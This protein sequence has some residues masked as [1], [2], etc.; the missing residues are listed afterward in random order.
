M[1]KLLVICMAFI[2]LMPMFNV[3]A[4]ELTTNDRIGVV[5]DIDSTAQPL[6][7][8]PCPY[9]NG[10]CMMY[11]RGNGSIYVS[12]TGMVALSNKKCWQCNKCYTV[13]VTEGDVAIG[14]SFG[15]YAFAPW[16]EPSGII[17]TWIS[18]TSSEV[19]YSTATSMEGYKFMYA[20]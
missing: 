16:Y 17:H 5:S 18:V 13:A 9:G 1:K 10:I 12:N 3:Y 8:A 6:I 11:R 2:L 19:H 15:T 20:Q 7:N 4:D 14:E